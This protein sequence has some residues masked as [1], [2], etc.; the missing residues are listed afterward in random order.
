MMEDFSNLIRTVEIFRLST[1]EI[2]Y[3]LMDET[4]QQLLRETPPQDLIVSGD[5]CHWIKVLE[6]A[7]RESEHWKEELI[8]QYM[9]HRNT[10]FFGNDHRIAI[11]IHFHK[12]Q[13]FFDLW[14]ST[15]H[16]SHREYRL[17]TSG[18]S[19]YLVEHKQTMSK[20]G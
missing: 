9:T 11:P 20:D 5:R 1:W 15:R 18:L 8:T 12:L 14:H 3:P 10:E 17:W 2:L 19:I 16:T 13:Q 4:T 6:K 7:I